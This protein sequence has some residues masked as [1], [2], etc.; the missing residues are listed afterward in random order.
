MQMDKVV[1][2]GEVVLA[3]SMLLACS[4]SCYS[5]YGDHLATTKQHAH[6]MNHDHCASAPP[7]IA[8]PFHYRPPYKGPPN[9][10]GTKGN[11]RRAN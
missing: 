2:L 1:L 5:T 7:L 10:E 11:G 3:L 4:A 9:E 6:R 8:T